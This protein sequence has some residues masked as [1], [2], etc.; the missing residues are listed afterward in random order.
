MKTI[1]YI[2]CMLIFIIIMQVIKH[3]VFDGDSAAALYS[4]A[5]TVLGHYIIKNS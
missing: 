3:I 4:L 5:V 2:I 1:T